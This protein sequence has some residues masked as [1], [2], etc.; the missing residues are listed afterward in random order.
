MAT[1]ALPYAFPII[2]FT[3][4]TVAFAKAYVS[5]P[6]AFAIRFSEQVVAANPVTLVSVSTGMSNASQ[7]FT[8]SAA[9][10]APFG[11][12]AASNFSTTS[13]FS[14]QTSVRL[15]TAPM[16][17]PFKRINPATISFA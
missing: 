10:S 11:E 6:A 4:G 1:Y 7:K 12:I 8:N 9:F 3:L 15:A 17:A 16:V 13:P 5:L 2:T 14:S